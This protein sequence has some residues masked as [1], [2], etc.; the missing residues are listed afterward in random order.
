MYFLNNYTIFSL[1]S[2]ALLRFSTCSMD[3]LSKCMW[4][5]LVRWFI[6]FWVSFTLSLRLC[7]CYFISVD[8][9]LGRSFTHY[10]ENIISSLFCVMFFV[11][12]DIFLLLLFDSS[13]YIYSREWRWERG[14]WE[15]KCLFIISREFLCG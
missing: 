1:L 7:Y 9:F 3:N 15:R 6:A 2:C 10:D 8:C 4:M 13:I 14:Q 5:Y 12:L 11:F